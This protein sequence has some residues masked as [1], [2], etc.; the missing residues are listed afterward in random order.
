KNPC[1]TAFLET[2]FF[3]VAV[4]GPV[5]F[6]EFRRFDS[7]FRRETTD[8]PLTSA[9]TSLNPLDRAFVACPLL[10]SD[11]APDMTESRACGFSCRGLPCRLWFFISPSFWQFY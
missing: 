9:L 6:W 4:F 7:T 11:L 3:P 8:F 2:L 10:V 5:D 1:R